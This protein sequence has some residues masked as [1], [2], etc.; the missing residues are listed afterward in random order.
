[1]SKEKRDFMAVPIPSRLNLT[2]N[3]AFSCHSDLAC[4]N[5]CCRNKH[6]PLTP[7]D[8]L[9]LK[10]ALNIHSDEFLSHYTLYRLDP[11]SGFPII[12]LKMA[13]DSRKVCPFVCQDGCRLYKDRPTA[14]RLYPLG[15][16]SRI[17]QDGTAREEFFFLLDTPDCLGINEKRIRSVETWLYDQGINPYIEMNNKM[18]GILFHPNRVRTTPLNEGQLQQ[19]MVA[20]YNLDLFREFIFKTRFLESF[21]IGEDIHLK[22][23]GDDTAL[24]DLAFDYLDLALF[25]DP[26]EDSVS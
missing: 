25:P 17:I 13:D 9:R 18:L 7:Y 11:D 20:C 2:D 14:C 15:R 3:F 12:S 4:F 21:E 22:I 26:H 16:A 8:I 5:K 6:L 23:E 19:V 1:M 10:T 24:L